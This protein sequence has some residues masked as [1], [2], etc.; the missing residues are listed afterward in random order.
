MVGKAR[1]ATAKTA[2]TGIERMATSLRIVAR[3]DAAE[4]PL[5]RA[6]RMSRFGY[7]PAAARFAKPASAVKL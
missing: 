3:Y 2:A 4:V 6:R 1:S 7:L 5:F